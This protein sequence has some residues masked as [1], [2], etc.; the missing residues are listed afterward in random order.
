MTGVLPI[1][2]AKATRIIQA[3]INAGKEY[4]ALMHLHKKVNQDRLLK[5][6][7]KFQGKIRQI[8]PVRSAV[9]RVERTREI[10]YFKI[11]DIIDQDILFRVGCE[12]GTYIRKLIHDLGKEIG[13]GAHM[14]QLV[15]TKAGPFNDYK[16]HSLQDIKDAY[17]FY[18]EGDESEIRK[19]ILPYEKATEHLPKVWVFDNV[20][21]NL[22]H[23]SSLGN[24]GISKLTTNI[25]SNDPVA[26]FTLKDE[27]ICLGKSLLSFQDVIK[28]EK[29]LAV[30]PNKVFMD[31]TRVK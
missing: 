21:G 27:L 24:Q 20:I 25:K 9:K 17:E 3:L 18:K 12:A 10:Y 8:P 31:I 7:E 19:I 22:C 30:V 15:R 4:V 2:L 13:T 29:T 23:G 14:L 5:S 6:I 26:V 16:W 11:L 28:K 1:A